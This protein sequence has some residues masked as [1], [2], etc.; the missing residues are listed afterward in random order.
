MYFGKKLEQAEET[1][2]RK[3][4]IKW[5][6]LRKIRKLEEEAQKWKSYYGV[7]GQKTGGNW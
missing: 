5:K 7:D 6:M 4:R 1:S 2:I 3:Y